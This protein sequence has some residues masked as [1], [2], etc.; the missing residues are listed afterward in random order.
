M[1]TTSR[2]R[3]TLRRNGGNVG[4]LLLESLL[5]ALLVSVK[6]SGTQLRASRTT[7]HT[8]S[9]RRVTMHAVRLRCGE[10][11]Y[12]M[13]RHA[14]VACPLQCVDADADDS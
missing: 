2:R 12:V 9:Q 10:T 14:A 4:M 11:H 1:N 8:G 3:Q 6:V 7:T 5:T 13:P